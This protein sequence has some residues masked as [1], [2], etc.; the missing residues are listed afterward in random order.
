MLAVSNMNVRHGVNTKQG[1]K[2][3]VKSAWTY[4]Y[5]LSDKKML[6]PKTPR[7]TAFAKAK[8]YYLIVPKNYD[9]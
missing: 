5:W 7:I 3:K 2:Y 1:N 4:R 8:H 9:E 6:K